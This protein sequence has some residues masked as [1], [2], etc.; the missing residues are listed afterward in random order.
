MKV[1]ILAGGRGTR[2]S[3]E[4]YNR[5]KPMIE[6]GGRPILWHIMKMYSHN[7]FNDF[8][9][10]LGYLGHVIKDYFINYLARSHSFTIKLDTGF[11][12]YH[13][14]KSENEPWKVTLLDTGVDSGTA[15]RLIHAEPHITGETFM[16]TYGDGV[17]NISIS[18]LLRYHRS[19]SKKV[20]I[21]VVQPD[22][23]L[24]VV[25]A[26][27][28]GLVTSF[29]EKPPSDGWSSCGFFVMQKN[30]LQFLRGE[31]DLEGEPLVRLL[32]QQ[33]LMAYQHHGF[34][35]CMDTLREKN[36]LQELWNSDKAE[37]RVW[38]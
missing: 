26:D 9:I 37:W 25:T 18:D 30:A 32:Q 4:T 29:R 12:D 17:A 6:I 14:I 11:I 28:N 27:N 16:L 36:I 23:K 31:R 10:C 24:G 2:L 22:S 13:S 7:G 19:H 35:Q 20:T 8:V 33:E 1:V 38:K 5:P 3:E 21:S 34:W 15:E